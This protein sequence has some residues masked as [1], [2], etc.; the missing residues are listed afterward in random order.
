MQ[1]CPELFRGL[2][3]LSNPA[4][5]QLNDDGR[6]RWQGRMK[7]YRKSNASKNRHGA[8]G[9]SHRKQ[10]SG[11][12]GRPGNGQFTPGTGHHGLAMVHLSVIVKDPL[13]LFHDERVQARCLIPLAPSLL[14][15]H[16]SRLRRRTLS[17]VANGTYEEHN[18][19]HGNI[20]SW[21]RR[22]TRAVFASSPSLRH[23]L[24]NTRPT[25]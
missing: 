19:R 13:L 2:G 24:Q 9:G 10:N 4:I 8:R 16:D 11:H 23:N 22:A 15:P 7:S 14:P 12:S 18:P 20:F 25:T 3:G 1:T 21:F 17:G 5:R 6:R